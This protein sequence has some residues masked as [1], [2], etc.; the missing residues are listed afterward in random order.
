MKISTIRRIREEDLARGG[1]IPSSVK[2]M[3][4]PLNEFIEQIVTAVAGRLSLK[5]NFDT[6][7]VEMKIES[8]VPQKISIPVGRRVYGVM[9]VECQNEQITAY[10][11]TRRSDGNIDLNV[12]HTGSDKTFC[13]IIIFLE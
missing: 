13:R 2:A 11:F 4:G 9:P 3:L 5:D 8:G 12:D 6:K 10:G 1:D 7:I